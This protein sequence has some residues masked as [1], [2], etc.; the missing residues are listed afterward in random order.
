MLLDL[1]VCC[2]FVWEKGTMKDYALRWAVLLGKEDAWD[3]CGAS[4]C[5]LLNKGELAGFP[6]AQNPCLSPMSRMSPFTPM[7]SSLSS[8]PAAFTLSTEAFPL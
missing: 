1:S 6:Y 3:G 8:F 5:S 2:G 4:G 7:L